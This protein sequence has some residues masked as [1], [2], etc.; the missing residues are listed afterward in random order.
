MLNLRHDFENPILRYY[1]VELDESASY[2]L[3][4]C[5]Q[6]EGPPVE[7]GFGTST[8]IEVRAKPILNPKSYFMAFKRVG[9]VTGDGY[10]A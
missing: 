2:W 4:G 5:R 1:P 7:I 8:A 6:A 10:E 3:R 9:D